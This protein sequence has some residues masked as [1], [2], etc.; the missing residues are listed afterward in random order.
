MPLSDRV[1]LTTLIAGRLFGCGDAEVQGDTFGLLR[2]HGGSGGEG[3]AT[4]DEL[5]STIN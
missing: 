4:Y 2:A 1:K 3:T 5:C